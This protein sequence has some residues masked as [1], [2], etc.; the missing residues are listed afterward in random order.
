MEGV[1]F[2]NDKARTIRRDIIQMISGAKSGHPAGALGMADIFAALYFKILNHKPEEPDWSDRDKLVLSNGHISAVRYSSMAR[3]GY[4]PVEELKS[5]RKLNSRLQG[6][7]SYKDLPGVESSSGSLGQ[8][9]SIAVGMA[10]A[11]RLDNKESKIYCVVSDGELDEGSSWEAITA[12]NKWKLDNLIAIVDRNKI[13]IS[14]N[15]EE[16]WPLESLKDK[17]LAYNWDVIE[18][19]GNSM[20]EILEAFE[21]AK[22]IVGKPVVIIAYTV[23]GKGVSFMENNYEWHGRPPSKEEAKIALE[24]LK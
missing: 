15:S 7:P 3:S 17:F 1:N 2:L 18:I 21:K 11:S 19:D 4:F 14:G 20:E 23:P 8:G 6:H 24:E 16:I 9:L 22:Q 10:L 5:F 12:A 13:Q